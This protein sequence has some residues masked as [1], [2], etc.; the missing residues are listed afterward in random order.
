M[1]IIAMLIHVKKKSF[2]IKKM[3]GL[4]A[5]FG[6]LLEATI[7]IIILKV[8]VAAVRSVVEKDTAS[9]FSI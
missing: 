4:R 1:T 9:L 2:I 7:P 5:I 6:I 3:I 8:S